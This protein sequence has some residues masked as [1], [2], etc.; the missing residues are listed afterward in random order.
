MNEWQEIKFNLKWVDGCI[1]VYACVYEWMNAIKVGES[2][3]QNTKID[4][5][6]D[7]YKIQ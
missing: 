3:A 2:D 6:G 4:V 1:K 7:L 5:K